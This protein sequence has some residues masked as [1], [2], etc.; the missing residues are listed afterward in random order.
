[1]LIHV[2]RYFGVFYFT[3]A[4]DREGGIYLRKSSAFENRLY[5]GS[6]YLCYFT[7]HFLLLR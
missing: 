1:M 6:V 5:Y 2:R 3:F 7:R 4:F